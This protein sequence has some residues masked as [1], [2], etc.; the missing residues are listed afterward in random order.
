[1]TIRFRSPAGSHGRLGYA[2][3][4]AGGGW[5]LI[6]VRYRLGHVEICTT[7]TSERLTGTALSEWNARG[8]L[9]ARR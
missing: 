4:A 5:D 3:T 9:A 2:A 6:A 7:D 8:I 1:M